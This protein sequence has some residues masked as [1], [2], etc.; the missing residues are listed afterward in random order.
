MICTVSAACC[1]NHGQRDWMSATVPETSGAANDVPDILTTPPW[2][3][4]TSMFSPGATMKWFISMFCGAQMPLTTMQALPGVLEND[5]I[6]PCGPTEPTMM[7][8]EG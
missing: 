6:V 1:C 2:P 7:R 3:S 4:S 8:F 5:E